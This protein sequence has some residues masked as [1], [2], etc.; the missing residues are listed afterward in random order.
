MCKNAD[1]D[2]EPIVLMVY[3]MDALLSVVK[4]QSNLHKVAEGKTKEIYSIKGYDNDL[5]GKGRLANKTTTHVFEYLQ[6]LGIDVYYF[7][8]IFHVNILNYAK[9][10]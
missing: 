10:P 4:D 6:N 1:E 3:S 9:Q 5:E 2:D 7:S 8:K